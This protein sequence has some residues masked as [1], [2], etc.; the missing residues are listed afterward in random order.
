MEVSLPPCRVTL[1]PC[2][3]PTAPAGAQQGDPVSTKTEGRGMRNK[4]GM[5]GEWKMEGERKGWKE[6]GGV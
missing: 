6:G 3:L 1:A 2:P 4:E 5:I